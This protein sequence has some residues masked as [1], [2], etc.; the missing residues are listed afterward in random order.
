MYPPL[1]RTT[2]VTRMRA[3]IIF[4]FA[5]LV[6]ACQTG[7]RS[8]ARTWELPSGVKVAPVNGY[9]MAYVERGAGVPLILVHGSGVDY[10]YFANQME[11]LSAKYRTIAVSLRRYYPEP[12]RGEGDF[13]L[14]Q[15][16]ADLVAFIRSLGAGPVHLV[17]HSRGGTTALYATRMAP[18]LIRSLTFADGGLGMPAFAPDDPVVRDRRTTALRAMAEKLSKGETDAGLEIFVDFVNGPGA[19]KTTPDGTRQ[20]LRDNA[21]TLAAAEADT[22]T[23]A[24]FTCDDA[25]RLDVPVLLL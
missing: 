19:W 17:G 10:R 6:S 5:V 3:S 15:P 11:P 16:A 23:W 7:P 20:S 18:E 25:K 22:A 14:N 2:K 8:I 9:E 4:A 21:W 24:P 12:W 1:S 13:S